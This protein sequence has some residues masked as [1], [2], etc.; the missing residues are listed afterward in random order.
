MRLFAALTPPEAVLDHLELA[1]RQVAAPGLPPSAATA[2]A[3][4]P[5]N[6]R[7]LTPRSTWHITLAFFGQVPAGPATTLA[8]QFSQVVAAHPPFALEL[9]GAGSFA[10]RTAWIGLGGEVARLKA[11]MAALRE[12]WPS[13]GDEDPGQSQ[14]P[15][16]TISRRA[17]L[18]DWADP[19]KALAIY[20]GPAW[21]VVS[22]R[23]IESKPGQGP[24]GH[25]LYTTLAAADLGAA[26]V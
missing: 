3:T 8:D 7:A 13:Q 23:L 10:G 2:L 4:P 9:S 15:H 17:A 20:R 16:L 18:P 21:Q 25:A 6:R 24:G 12:L 1:L 22:A 11:L 5:R 26:P 14:R 19:L